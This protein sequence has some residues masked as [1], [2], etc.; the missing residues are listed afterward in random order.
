[1]HLLVVHT[2]CNQHIKLPHPNRCK[3]T[4]FECKFTPSRFCYVIHGKCWSLSGEKPD[5]ERCNQHIKVRMR[6]R[7]ILPVLA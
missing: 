7:E 6:N 1:V 2:R 5:V 3:I 4:V